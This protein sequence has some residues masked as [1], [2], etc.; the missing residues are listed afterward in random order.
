MRHDELDNCIHTEKSAPRHIIHAGC[1]FHCEGPKNCRRSSGRL[2][3]V[4]MPNVRTRQVAENNKEERIDCG[5]QLFAYG[6]MTL[7]EFDGEAYVALRDQEELLKPCEGLDVTAS[8]EPSKNSLSIRRRAPQTLGNRRGE[9]HCRRGK[10]ARLAARAARCA[11][12]RP[13]PPSPCARS[14]K[15]CDHFRTSQSSR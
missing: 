3:A 8:F 14:R 2:S 6:Q 11:P 1:G 10:P 9:R 15:G 7:S 13:R 12:P 5:S 4:C